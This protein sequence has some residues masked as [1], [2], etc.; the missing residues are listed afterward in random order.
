MEDALGKTFEL[1]AMVIFLFAALR[2]DW[3]VKLLS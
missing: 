1:I 2:I 3:S